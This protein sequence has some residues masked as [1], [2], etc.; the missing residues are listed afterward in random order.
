MFQDLP[1]GASTGSGASVRPGFTASHARDPTTARPAATKNDAGQP[2]CVATNGVREA[3]ATAPNC[4]TIFITPETD[5]AEGPAM[6]AVTDQKELWE[7]YTEPAP[8]ASTM[9]ARRASCA[10][11]PS[12]MN[13]AASPSPATAI[14]QTPARFPYRFVRPSLIQPPSGAQVAIATNGSIAKKELDLRSRP[15]SVLR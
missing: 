1:R 6:P 10:S 15:R 14:P 5:P 9:V 12:A 3:A 8:P 2:Q 13:R 7:R 4:P 11:I